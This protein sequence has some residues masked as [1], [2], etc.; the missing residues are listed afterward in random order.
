[1]A[2]IESAAKMGT[3]PLDEWRA[4][5]LI[6]VVKNTG[7][8]GRILDPFCDTGHIVKT[9]GDAWDMDAFGI[10]LKE[11]AAR[12]AQNL[13]G[14]GSA[15]YA[16]SYSGV[17]V[18]NASFD[19]LYLNPPYDTDYSDMSAQRSEYK[20]LRH[21]WKYLRYGGLV[22]W[23]AYKHHISKHVAGFFFEKC[24]MVYPFYWEKPHL[25]NYT[26]VCLVG[27]KKD[28]D[29]DQP[30]SPK[31]IMMGTEHLRRV[32]TRKAEEN[33]PIEKSRFV[34]L[35]EGLTKS[36][37]YMAMRRK[38]K[39][40][41]TG[42]VKTVVDRRI[43]IKGHP[44]GIFSFSRKEPDPKL[45]VEMHEKYGPQTRPEFK[46]IFRVAILDEEIQPIAK[47]RSGQL[48]VIMASGLLDTET[49]T[50]NGKRCMIRGNTKHRTLTVKT[51][52]EMDANNNERTIITEHTIPTP[53]VTI[54]YED[55]AV[56]NLTED[57]SLVEF[58]GEHMDQ[59]FEIYR[60]K[61]QPSYDMKID[62][63]WGEIFD[64]NLI[65]GQYEYLPTQEYMAVAAAE[66]LMREGRLVVVGEMSLGKT[67]I[68]NAVIQM[69]HKFEE[70]K[71]KNGN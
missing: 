60:N 8:R 4:E 43:A 41:K 10:E 42:A 40:K 53:T 35:G 58:I 6:K 14:E 54:V 19:I 64:N 65:K 27:L 33:I 49:L 37:K 17:R 48:G 9:L 12:Q 50:H 1:M 45:A 66:H 32:G 28:S 25:D 59:L 36:H 52:E 5:Q 20:A 56:E 16:D 30:L 26:Q 51:E 18:T 23:V 34:E 11:E 3:Y 24:K 70:V 38:V 55:G 67:A 47:P 44:G 15:I 61:Y 21:M 13:L 46:D 39:N 31:A 71:L 68:A 62:P 29:K 57:D 63:M 22:I 7:A 2:R 69:A